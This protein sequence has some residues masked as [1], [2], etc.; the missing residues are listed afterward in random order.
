MAKTGKAFTGEVRTWIAAEDL[1]KFKDIARARGLKDTE[2]A[3]EMILQGLDTLEADQRN[4]LESI[5]AQQLRTSTDEINATIKAGVNRICGLMAKVAVTALASNKFLSRLEDT[6]DMMKEC[7]G[8][9]A[10]QV[11]DGLNAEEQ[12][13]ARAMTK[14]VS[15]S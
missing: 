9:A 1:V 11:H 5:Y 13:V 3:R 14:K 15:D 2:L 8:A 6:E 12:A 7:T 4:R 10:K